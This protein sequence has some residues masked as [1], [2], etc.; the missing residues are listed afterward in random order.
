MLL[1]ESMVMRGDERSG[2]R[3]Q[4]SGGLFIV[5]VIIGGYWDA[6]AKTLFCLLIVLTSVLHLDGPLRFLG[7]FP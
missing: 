7:W 4:E 3:G 1:R 6:L 2:E 5:C